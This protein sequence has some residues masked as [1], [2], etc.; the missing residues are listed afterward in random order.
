[1]L[2]ESTNYS[3][4][5]FYGKNDR[6]Q[7]MFHGENGKIYGFLSI[8]PCPAPTNGPNPGTKKLEGMF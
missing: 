3:M 2:D 4:D 6:K 5:W 1:M 8:F 7:P